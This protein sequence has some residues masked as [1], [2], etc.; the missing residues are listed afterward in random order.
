MNEYHE[1]AKSKGFHD[2]DELD[3]DGHPTPRQLLAWAALVCSEWFKWRGEKDAWYLSEDGKPEGKVAE[4][5]DVW[6]RCQDICGALKLET[7]YGF[8]DHGKWFRA[9][10]E[11]IEGARSGGMECYCYALVE[12]MATAHGLATEDIESFQLSEIDG[13]PKTFG[14]A[15]AIKHE[16]NK[17]RPRMHGKKA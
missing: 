8:P 9:C 13:A 1:L 14:E 10:S 16:Y 4:L 2:N 15:I 17:T 3:Y 5:A 12:M 6:I 11:L 7:D